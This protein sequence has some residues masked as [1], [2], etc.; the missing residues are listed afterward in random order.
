MERSVQIWWNL[1]K[2]AHFN[3]DVRIWVRTSILTLIIHLLLKLLLIQLLLE[4][5]HKVWTEL[6]DLSKGPN[7]KTF[8]IKIGILIDCVYGQLDLRHCAINENKR[9]WEL[10]KCQL[11]SVY[12]QLQSVAWDMFTVM[13]TTLVGG[14]AKESVSLNSTWNSWKGVIHATKLVVF[15]IFF[16]LCC[17]NTEHHWEFQSMKCT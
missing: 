13:C 3:Y 6:L 12:H 14:R 16:I 1:S 9:I 5:E 11:I 8:L 17:Q 15:F 4:Q 7:K 10:V 2:P